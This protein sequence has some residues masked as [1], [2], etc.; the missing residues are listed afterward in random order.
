LVHA[1][2]PPCAALAGPIVA[3]VDAPVGI[4]DGTG[5][6]VVDAVTADGIGRG[7]DAATAGAMALV[8]AAG[9]R[10]SG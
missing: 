4:V 9:A 3:I 5:I 1:T 10:C 7:I 6:F 2:R 8:P